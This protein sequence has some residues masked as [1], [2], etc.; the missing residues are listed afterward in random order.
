MSA[1]TQDDSFFIKGL[2]FSVESVK[3]PLANPEQIWSGE[4]MLLIPSL[5]DEKLDQISII[6]LLAKPSD[7]TYGVV[8]LASSFAKTELYFKLGALVPKS[9]Q[10]GQVVDRLKKGNYSETVVFAN[11][12][13][14]I[15]LPDETCRI[16]IID[17]KP[18]FQSL[19]DRYEEASRI[20][21]D[22]INIKIA[23]K[24]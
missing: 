2:G 1:T 7:K 15:D 16:L 10:I 12:Y 5:I 20:N 6:N 18:F 13:D 8:A 4:K 9:D 23:Q 21:S 22:S 3:N 14:G 17:G 24:N 11:R 19:S